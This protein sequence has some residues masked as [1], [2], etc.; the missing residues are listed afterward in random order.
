MDHINFRPWVGTRYQSAGFM[1]KRILVLGESHYCRDYLNPGDKC[2]PYC[3]KEIMK[4]DCHSQT[5]DVINNVIYDYNGEPYM[6]TFLCFERA[7]LGK[8]LSQNERE[9]FWQSVVFYN[10]IQYSQRDSR[11]APQPDH[12]AKSE[13]AFKELIEQYMPD[14]IVVWG[15]RLYDGLPD[16]NGVPSKLYINDTDYTDIWTYTIN[17]KAIPAMKVHH[18]SSPSGKCWEYWHLFYDKF[19][20]A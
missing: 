20:N 11:M 13:L 19:L 4:D 17:G 8:A 7:I 1:G 10:Y 12:W 9:F 3:R 16:W 18:P 14:C 15:A 5:E 2:Y 6:R